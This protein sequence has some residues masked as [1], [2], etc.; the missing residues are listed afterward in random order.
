MPGLDD[1]YAAAWAAVEAAVLRE[2]GSVDAATRAAIAHG[3]DPGE[4]AA[5]L[6]KVRRHA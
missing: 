1:P 3:D 2:P 6:D 4:L 5:L